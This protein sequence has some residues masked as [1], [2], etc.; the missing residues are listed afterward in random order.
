MRFAVGLPWWGY[1]LAFASAIVLGWLSYARAA[2]A[3]TGLVLALA[4]VFYLGVLP[5]RLLSIA[6]SSVSAIF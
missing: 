1:V 6:A 4:A 2:V 5:G 3:L